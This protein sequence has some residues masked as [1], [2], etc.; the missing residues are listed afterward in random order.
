MDFFFELMGDKPPNSKCTEIHLEPIPMIEIWEEYKRDMELNSDIVLDFSTFRKLWKCCFPHVKI[1][2]YKQVGQTCGTCSTLSNLRRTFKDRRSCEYI[3]MCHALHRATFMGERLAYYRRRVLAE[4]LPSEYLSLISDGMAQEHCKLP[5]CAN[6]SKVKTLPHHIQGVLMHGRTMQVYRTFHNVPNGGNLAIHTLLLSLEKVIVDEGKLPDTLFL[7]FDGGP[8]NVAQSVYAICEMLIAKGLTKHITLSR[9]ITG[10][11]HEDID[12]KFAKIWQKIKRG[13]IMTPD[14]WKSAIEDILSKPTVPC[15]AHNIFAVPD[16]SKFLK[17]HIANL[18]RY[19]KGQWTQLVFNFDAVPSSEH[20][21]CGVR[22]T[23][24]AYSQDEVVLIEPSI[25][26][27][28]GH[29]VYMN[30]FMHV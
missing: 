17:P 4:Q 2:Q 6:Y 3:K 9:L 29:N 5:W 8:E 10:H 21:P 11:T 13:Y 24:R 15:N 7:Q 16:Y 12:A 30:V 18:S 19:A 27:P 1:R 22:T 28:S 26:H 14:Q 20:F 25:M 23:Y